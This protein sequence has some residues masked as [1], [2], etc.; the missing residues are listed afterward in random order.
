[1][2]P[3]IPFIALAVTVAGT[4]VSINRQNASQRKQ[5]EAQK[6]SAAQAAIENQRRIREALA[7]ARQ[8]RAGLIAAG[9]GAGLGFES[10][11][12]QGGLGAQATQVASNVGFAKQNQA[13]SANINR[14]LQQANRNA[15]RASQFAAIASLPNS[16]GFDPASA[17]DQAKKDARARAAGRAST[18][19]K[20]S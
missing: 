7:A 12:I 4:A 8:D 10:S 6:V 16:F 17:V 3:A 18:P 14:S 11:P 15:S 13:F 5:R 20:P 19:I 2:A 1:M 9:F